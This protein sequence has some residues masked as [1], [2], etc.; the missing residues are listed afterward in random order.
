MINRLPRQEIAR[1]LV[2]LATGLWL[3][4]PFMTGRQIGAGDALWYT[5]ML[6]DYVTQLRA[7]IFPVFVGQ[8]DYAFNGAVYPLRVAP[9]Y[10]HLAVAIDLVTFRQLGFFALQHATVIVC[11]FAGLFVS[12]LALVRIAPAQRWAACGL[13]VLYVSCPG[14]LGT[15]VTQDLYMTWMTVPILPVAVYGIVRTFQHDDL[16]AQACLAAALAALWQSHS[17]IALWMTLIA[18]GTQAVRL[19]VLHRHRDAWFRALAGVALFVVLGL[20]PFVSLASLRVPGAT[21]TVTASLAHPEQ[22]AA[23][24]RAVFPAIL[25]PLSD[26]ARTLADLQLGYGLWLVLFAVIGASLL[27]ARW[28]MR[29]LLVACL[30]LLLLLLPVPFLND[31]LWLHL[32]ET[33]RRIT[34][35]WPMQRFYLILGAL[36]AAAG[37]LALAVLTDKREDEKTLAAINSP[38][39]LTSP[40][41]FPL[42]LTLTL[43]CGWSLWEARQFIRAGEERTASAEVSARDLRPENRLLMTHA[44]GFLPALPAYFSHGVMDPSVETRLL[45]RDKFE[46]MPPIVGTVVQTSDFQG[47]VDDNP[48][49]LKLTPTLQLE[50]GQRYVLDFEFSPHRYAGV[51]QLSGRTFFREY[52]LPQSGEPRAFGTESANAKSLSLWTTAAEPEVVTLRFIPTGGDKPGEFS[53]F[54]RFTFRKLDPTAGPATVTSLLPFRATVH[55]AA[56][57]WLETPRVYI[58]GYVATVDGHAT[59]VQRSPQGLVMIPVTAT[60]HEIE[61]RYQGP[62]GLRVSY[63]LSL[64]FWVALVIIGLTR[65]YAEILKS[66]IGHP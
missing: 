11:G 55:P 24:V 16:T 17:P 61:L 23:A 33:L 48:G 6:A 53:N 25:L 51:L 32:P 27:S 46:V 38:S 26:H 34:Y 44:Y 14:V 47:Q 60:T 66:R 35:Y 57:A 30:G 64:F 21:S 45:T 52:L 41:T 49:V 10:Q 59:E 42:T 13:A 9:L 40:L 5:H 22:I 50:P 18:G 36:L 28:D 29:L 15:I 4:H 54:A 20:Y 65:T 12:Y 31:W 37:Q 2:L 63:W 43:A 19:L 58:P 3:F 56:D 7:G 39:P 1:W 62:I 8:T